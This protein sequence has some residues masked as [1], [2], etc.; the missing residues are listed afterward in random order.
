MIT[1]H[2][3]KFVQSHEEEATTF[4]QNTNIFPSSSVQAAS[5]KNR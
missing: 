3:D 4:D 5:S 2:Y 1:A